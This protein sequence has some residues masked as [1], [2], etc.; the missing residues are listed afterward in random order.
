MKKNT[1]SL[2][3]ILSLL[4]FLNLNS[5]LFAKTIHKIDPVRFT[6]STEASYLSANEE[7]EIKITAKYLSIN[8]NLV[9]VFEGSNAFKLK[10]IMP[11]GFKQ[12]GGS[13]SDFVGTE[14]TSSKPSVT[15]T[16]KG[17]FTS[18]TKGGIF[19]LLRSHKSAGNQSEF[20]QVGTLAF[21]T[22]STSADT[23][24]GSNAR[25]A[26]V[27]QDYIPHMT[28][29]EFRA[30]MADTS[31][32]I[33]I[34]EGLKSGIFRYNSAIA[35]ADDSALVIIN[36]S[37]KYIR[38][39][40]VI[41]PE[42]FGAIPN[43]SIDD[44]PAIQK[45]LNS[46]KN[47]GMRLEFSE[48]TYL[49]GST[50][51]PKKV[52][53]KTKYKISMSGK[54]RGRTILKGIYSA[55]S[56]KNLIECLPQ[57]GDGSRA[58][59]DIEFKSIQFESNGANRILYA[60]YVVGFQISDC[61]F[62]GGEVNCIQIGENYDTYGIYIKDS[63]FNGST[64][65]SGQNESLIK[66][67]ARYPEIHSIV[68]DGGMYGIDSQGD[69][70][71]LS[72]STFEGSK[73]AAVYLH[74]VSGGSHKIYDNV[75]RPYV[76]YDTNGRFNG[77][78]QGV[79][80]ESV[81][82][83]NANNTISNN[84]FFVGTPE[85]QSK[86]LILKSITGTFQA[87]TDTAIHRIVGS[88]SG[89]SAGVIGYNIAKKQLILASVSGTFSLNESITQIN[90]S[91]TATATIDTL[92]VNHTY[93]LALLG[94][95]GY[96]TITGNQMRGAEIGVH[97]V[98]DGNVITGNEI[99]GIN[100]ILLENN[101]ILTGNSI[102][103][104]TGYAVKKVAGRVTWSNNFIND[105]P[106]VGIAP[107]PMTPVTTTERNAISATYPGI[108]A[109]LMLYDKTVNKLTFYNGSIWKYITPE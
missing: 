48:G 14:L 34:N 53:S 38:D 84:V 9:Y 73:R 109:G 56:G 46:I 92:P 60:D 97:S 103:V 35:T 96:S 59:S 36:S 89:A 21:T 80:I 65:N 24:A 37:R 31:K 18:D 30:G 41:R 22:I 100:G 44:A 108:P 19:Q 50:L 7:F 28:L 91:G 69:Q 99:E 10:L 52:E 16:V 51:K 29:T 23:I 57:V 5:Y 12:T 95:G 93:G 77:T 104:S 67:R 98:S 105:K 54:G 4:I 1:P 17:K 74:G 83:G 27:G 61:V 20:V 47:A 62:L 6:I 79:L 78:L 90:G 42:Y 32:V 63:Y 72:G 64:V 2:C 25:I 45:A 11:E 101:A 81:S 26:V 86:T 3:F 76:G 106:I 49:I 43:D 68:T 71:V 39:Y 58:Q 8:P 107:Q 33:Y 66:L 75:F 15:Y 102:N 88:S 55:I 70:L 40:D 85:E 87:Y 94:N 13:Y 82:G